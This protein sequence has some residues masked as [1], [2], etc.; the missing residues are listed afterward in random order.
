[1]VL[2]LGLLLYLYLR[3]SGFFFGLFLELW[4]YWIV[5]E[6]SWIVKLF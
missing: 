2:R 1:M 6:V 4:G 5:R 3:V